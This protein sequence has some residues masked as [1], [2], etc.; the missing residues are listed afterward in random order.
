[1]IFLRR[2][3]GR[4]NEFKSIFERKNEDDSEQEEPESLEDQKMRAMKKIRIIASYFKTAG[5]SLPAIFTKY[6]HLDFDRWRVLLGC[7]FRCDSVCLFFYR[8]KT[9][10][11]SIYSPKP[12]ISLYRRD[13]AHN[14]N[15]IF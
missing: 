15:R 5:P 10:Y 9:R 4:K 14:E 1:M 3:K 2:W 6:Y 13:L 8:R 12:L 11:H 7:L